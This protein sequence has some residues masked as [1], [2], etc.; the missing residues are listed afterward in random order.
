MTIPNV[1]PPT[2]EDRDPLAGPIDRLPDRRMQLAIDADHGSSVKDRCR[3]VELTRSGS[4]R[5]PQDGRHGV[6]GQRRQHGVQLT[7][8]HVNRNIG[9]VSRVVRQTSEDGLRAAEDSHS[10]RLTP[11]NPFANELDS[12]H[13]TTWKKGGLIGGYPHGIKV[14]KF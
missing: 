1:R 12:V 6:A 8:F 11:R 3:V 5:K 13:G 10:F 4:L 9:G 14:L 7:A 2:C